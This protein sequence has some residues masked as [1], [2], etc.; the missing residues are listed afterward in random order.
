MP[1]RMEATASPLI[2]PPKAR[3]LT[4][5]IT[6]ITVRFCT[7]VEPDTISATDFVL[8]AYHHNAT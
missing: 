3:R 4:A 8:Y 6:R 7:K 1:A 2:T 5:T